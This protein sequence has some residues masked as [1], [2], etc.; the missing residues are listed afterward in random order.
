MCHTSVPQISRDSQIRE[1]PDMERQRTNR[2]IKLVL[3]TLC[4]PGNTSLNFLSGLLE[5]ENS[6][7]AKDGVTG[8]DT[9]EKRYGMHLLEE[10][11]RL[12]RLCITPRPPV[13]ESELLR[14]AF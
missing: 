13:S 1:R 8:A 6:P 7:A 14:E 11:R 10:S 4:S 3:P 9:G 5:V 12:D 2:V